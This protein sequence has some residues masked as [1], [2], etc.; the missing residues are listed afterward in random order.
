V[1]YLEFHGEGIDA[2][3][4]QFCQTYLIGAGTLGTHYRGTD[5]EEEAA[6]LGYD[7]AFSK[8]GE[9]PMQRPGVTNL[10]VAS[11]EQAFI[12]RTAG[13]F[14]HLSVA[15]FEASVRSQDGRPVHLGQ[16]AP[17]ND[18]MGRDAL[19]NSLLLSRCGAVVR[20]GSNTLA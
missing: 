18:L 11:D 13:C 9:V 14:P 15:T 16:R 17:G 7:A 20:K 6:L 12:D 2:A 5:K 8:V 10:F 3:V 4:D 19:M 1:L